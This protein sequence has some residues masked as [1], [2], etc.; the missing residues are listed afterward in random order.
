MR[1]DAKMFVEQALLLF[2]K[3]G[4]SIDELADKSGLNRTTIYRLFQGQRDWV[5]RSTAT[6]IARG[7]G[8]EI[9]FKRSQVRLFLANPAEKIEKILEDSIS[10]N[11]QEA[12]IGR[13]MGRV[14]E[15]LRNVDTE[16]LEIA[17]DLV[18]LIV[19]MDK[20]DLLDWH[21]VQKTLFGEENRMLFKKKLQAFVI[22]VMPYHGK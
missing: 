18:R 3:A 15:I 11:D 10:I 20:D 16:V 21:H 13:F 4:M 5:D 1:A 8:A 22:L 14:V 7:L 9:E 12:A 19:T 17:E 2:D 6:K